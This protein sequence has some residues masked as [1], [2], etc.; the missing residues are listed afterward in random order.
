MWTLFALLLLIGLIAYLM[1]FW[2]PDEARTTT[3]GFGTETNST[4]SKTGYPSLTFTSG[5]PMQIES[6]LTKTDYSKLL[7]YS[8]F[9]LRKFWLFY[10]GVTLIIALLFFLMFS[11]SDRTPVAFALLLSLL[12]SVVTLALA[13]VVAWLLIKILPNR[14]GTVLGLH[15]FTLTDSEF[16]EANAAGSASMKL[17]LLR[18]HETK[19]HIFL[20]TPMHVGHILPM[21]DLQAHPDFLRMLRARTRSA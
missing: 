12:I 13:T 5:S 16:Q 19:Q 17:E 8:T 14:P 4:S 18:R 9:R 7:R 20:F 6:Q 2:S 15:T 1:F 11:E 3:V 21:Q 10:V